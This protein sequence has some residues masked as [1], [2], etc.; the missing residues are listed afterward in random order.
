MK[1]TK[2]QKAINKKQRYM[3]TK[4]YADK[5]AKKQFKLDFINARSAMI[6]RDGGK[7]V[8]CKK[9]VGVHYQT[10]HI[11]PQEFKATHNEVDNLLLACFYHHKVGKY[12]MHNHPL[13]VSK[14][15]QINRPGQYAW[16]MER[17]DA[18]DY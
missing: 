2:K 1:L 14:W 16:V 13:W 9:V 10:C 15:L 6:V 4:A 18:E 3:Q 7:C 8:F 12:S 11:I 17:I 5:I